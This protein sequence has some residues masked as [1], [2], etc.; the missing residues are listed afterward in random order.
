MGNLIPSNP[1]NDY[2]L[3]KFNPTK[4]SGCRLW[5]DATDTSKMYTT[6]YMGTVDLNDNFL[7]TDL[8]GCSTWFDSSD[9]STIYTTSAGPV[10]AVSS[11][12]DISGCALWLDASDISTQKQ[13]SDGTV[14]VADGEPIGYWEDKSGN[15]R[16][17]IQETGSARP[18]RSGSQNGLNVIT[19]DG[20]N[21]TLTSPL[22]DS[23][24]QTIFWIVKTINSPDYSSILN[25]NGSGGNRAI[26]I[27]AGGVWKWYGPNL[28]SSQSTSSYA[29]MSLVISSSN[30][31]ALYQ[32]GW[33]VGTADPT[34][35][36][37]GSPNNLTIGS[38]GIYTFK[39]EV[40]EIII[41]N[42][43]LSISERGRVEKYLDSKWG[44][45][46]I[47]LQTNLAGPIGYWGD[48]SGNN[49]HARQERGDYRPT[50]SGTI[51][52]LPAIT[53]D[54]SNDY[55]DLGNIG[56]AFPNFGE[57]F[58]VFEPDNA[59][60]Y[61]LY[62][63][64][65]NYP[66]FRY[67][68]NSSSF[69]A[70]V[71]TRA[72]PGNIAGPTY[73]VHITSMRANSSS[74]TVRLDGNVW[75]TQS[76][77]GYSGGWWH[78]IGYSYQGT[79]GV[80]GIVMKGKI[81]EV[82]TY[83]VDIGA[84]NRA[85]VEQYLARKWGI[86][87]NLHDKS[88]DGK[89]VGYWISKGPNTAAV[90]QNN[91]TKRPILGS[92]NGK[93]AVE[94]SSTQ[95]YLVNNGVNFQTSNN[96]SI[97]W[98]GRILNSSGFTAFRLGGMNYAAIVARF[99]SALEYGGSVGVNLNKPTSI[100]SAFV[101]SIIKSS[102]TIHANT[103]A[104]RN[105]I[106]VLGSSYGTNSEVSLNSGP[107]VMGS[108]WGDTQSV[109]NT[110][111][112]VIGEFIFYNRS[113]STAERN[114][115]E[116]YLY[117]KWNIDK[118][119]QSINKPT[120]ISGCT[121]WLDADDRKTLF[122]DSRATNPI[123][124]DDQFVAYWA[125]KA[126]GQDV[127]Q[128]GSTS[129]C[130]KY[131]INILNGK[132]MLYFDGG[133][134]LLSQVD[135]ITTGPCTII[136]V[137][138][139]DSWSGDIS[140]VITYGNSTGGLGGPGIVYNS[141]GLVFL[142]GAGASTGASSNSSSNTL[143]LPRIMTAV[144]TQ[145][146]TT[147]SYF[148]LNGNLEEYFSGSGVALTSNTNRV[149]IGGRTGSGQPTRKMVGYIAEC[150]TYNRVLN[151]TERSM[152]ENYLSEKWGIGSYTPPNNIG[153]G[154]V[155]HKIKVSNKDAQNWVNRV[156]ENGGSVSEKTADLVNSFC[157]SIDTAGL[158]DKFYRLNLFCGNDLNACLTP[159]YL[160]PDN[161]TFYGFRTEFST[162]LI[163]PPGFSGTN[164]IEKIGLTGN[165][166]AY[167]L[168]GISPNSIGLS[169]VGHYSVYQ[170]DFNF[171]NPYDSARALIGTGYSTTNRH[172]LEFN[173]Q[174]A[175]CAWGGVD[176]TSSS[177][178][179]GLYVGSRESLS[180]I[181]SYEQGLETASSSSGSSG[182]S[183]SGTI[184]VFG[185]TSNTGNS[186]VTIYIGTLK[187]YSVGKP[188][189]S[190]EVDSFNTIMETFQSGL[191]RGL[192][193]RSSSSFSEVTNEDAKR[194]IDN[195][196]YNGGTVSSSTALAVNNFCNS[197]DSA[198]LRNKFYRLNLFCGNNINSCL[199]PIY[200]GPTKLGMIYGN[201]K[202]INVLNTAG[203]NDFVYSESDGLLGNTQDISGNSFISRRY[204]RTG[205]IT[206]SIT[207]LNN[208]LHS[209]VYTKTLT[210][211]GH[212]LGSY[213]TASTG[214]T[215]Q[216]GLKGYNVGAFANSLLNFLNTSTSTLYPS[217]KGLFVGNYSNYL[218]TAYEGRAELI[219]Q[220]DIT[221]TP[222]IPTTVSDMGVFGEYR[223]NNG[224]SLFNYLD[225]LQGYSIGSSLSSSDI[226][227]YYD[228]M[229]TFQSAL[230][231][232]N[233][234]PI[235]GSQF[236]SITNLDTR[237]W[238]TRVYKNNG[239]VSVTTA[240]AVQ[241]FCN[242]IDSA[243]LR[244]KFYRLNLFCGNNLEAC[245]VPLY[246]GDSRTGTQRGFLY[247]INNNFTI[248][249]YNE[250]GILS[251]IKGNGS[252][253]Y[254]ETGLGTDFTNNSSLSFGAFVTS[255]TE[256]AFSTYLGVF[257]NN[258]ADAT[259]LYYR[260]GFT[261]GL[262]GATFY[263]SAPADSILTGHH[264]YSRT[265]SNSFF[266]SW[267]GTS[268]AISNSSS[269]ARG[270]AGFT[271]H[272][273]NNNGTIANYGNGRISM[274]HIGLGL[275]AQQVSAFSAIVETF[276]AE[277]GRVR[278]S[279]QFASVT[280]ED[281]K[282]WVDNVYSNGGIVSSNTASAVNTL[283]DSINSNN[284]RS[285]F[286]RMNLFCGN[287]LLACLV[288]LYRGPDRTTIYGNPISDTN[289]NFIETN[290]SAN[291]LSGNGTNSYLNTGV[292]LNFKND[293]HLSV[294]PTSYGTTIYRRIIGAR[295]SSLSFA[296]CL[297]ITHDNPQNIIYGLA[298]AGEA[299]LNTGVNTAVGNASS[300]GDLHVMSI[301][302]TSTLLASFY[303][304]TTLFQPSTQPSAPS[305][306]QTLYVF[307]ENI[308]GSPGSS[309]NATL[310]MYSIGE[311]LSSSEISLLNPIIKTFQQ[312]IGR[313]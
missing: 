49:R 17:A 44:L 122:Q 88:D 297:A 216:I 81:V 290:Y 309:T 252:N 199:V 123:T 294:Y 296:N 177:Y 169:S 304:N 256:T 154:F 250:S 220:R 86:S 132:P 14:S 159:L 308:G 170:T 59:I 283:C 269:S 25:Y 127:I 156:F 67:A 55:F 241:N 61:E 15:N 279:S 240:T 148:Y 276:N 292:P 307:T 72:T 198:G 149:Q 254:L 291:G 272:A 131:K 18:I 208:N 231:R 105:N 237:D 22:Q 4:I 36:L 124:S 139:L 134:D 311:G 62:Q 128:T 77:L 95:N 215:L 48:K 172:Y 251:G 94:F 75:H 125:D 10:E 106:T 257:Q 133:D 260:D 300:P 284:L 42:R 64:V 224:I 270:K 233:V 286:Y 147:N 71:S 65:N 243:G 206:G 202:D 1:N 79:G 189:D 197:I 180:S 115:V 34:N 238:L 178:A 3:N 46:G 230:S 217:N 258:N 179:G 181:K 214:F 204:L 90:K 267:N 173:R 182:E 196:Y 6:D 203:S 295:E 13:N 221:S 219:G 226:Q 301:T 157:D 114:L 116:K 97:F 31:V 110:T 273:I 194:W 80:G 285:K 255:P 69:G 2:N 293:R 245:T 278:P 151:D 30:S 54:G 222:L 142:D 52:N 113:L 190:S 236:D 212:P 47:H 303:R 120:E 100:S 195:V 287:N 136:V 9:Q 20:I 84:Q 83:N 141:S 310:G 137:C 207:A 153:S 126:T 12:T 45:G 60:T 68:D 225:R 168:T 266:H 8:N 227:S 193:V 280:N 145:A 167:L 39:G 306:T 246:R 40:A 82:I 302:G 98:V 210:S 162:S 143:G 164:Y 78:T 26:Q 242:S 235:L 74:M 108:Y 200:L 171:Y 184:C 209:A 264:V 19:F 121:L 38:T 41:Y 192:P 32:S 76:G 265:A 244:N 228:I 112:L 144:Y 281:A 24:T 5:F 91:V 155:K 299:L 28:I 29:V 37:G 274:Y 23:D 176:I 211:G 271:I 66:I 96:F 99:T 163:G 117:E 103:S 89:K 249:D 7:P 138:R 201:T 33:Q 160:G 289:N 152:V 187:S 92:I 232:S 185:S 188:M 146:N 298:G 21:D 234:D 165:G 263:P 161:S 135:R 118:L 109:D 87:R 102:G 313:P 158:R 104:F 213:D 282:I 43:A 166:S 305:S 51:N 140:G 288:P 247:D 262:D 111:N 11:P 57:V 56:S 35:Q 259:V 119:N 239:T 312:S 229:Q 73:G 218:L 191:G 130:P 261:R 186:A 223:F 205:L 70:F 53:F 275:N 63:T 16:H 150:V 268:G 277:M 101:E 175:N 253:K 183:Q 27:S 85:K 50:Y 93:N 129:L 174:N 107:L 248:S 58:I